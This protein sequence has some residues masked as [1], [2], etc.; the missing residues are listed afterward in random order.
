MKAQLVYATDLFDDSTVESMA[1]RYLAILEAV[2]ADA[3]CIVGGDIVI[4]TA[5]E[6]AETVDPLPADIRLADLVSVAS[7][8]DP[9]GCCRGP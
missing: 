6:Q 9:P 2:A 5:D 1:Q 8:T 7:D 3:E 4:F